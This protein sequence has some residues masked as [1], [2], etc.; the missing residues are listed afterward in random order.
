[1]TEI[2]IL[3]VY[4]RLADKFGLDVGGVRILFIAA[5]IFD[6]HSSVIFPL[7]KPRVY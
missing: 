7:V 6:F 1:M 3:G 4:A 5:A 2:K